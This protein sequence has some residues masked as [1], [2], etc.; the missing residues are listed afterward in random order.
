MMY[1]YTHIL[2]TC[3]MFYDLLEMGHVPLF[4]VIILLNSLLQ[5]SFSSCWKDHEDILLRTLCMAWEDFC[6]QS[7][8]IKFVSYCPINSINGVAG[9][10][11]RENITKTVH[12]SRYQQVTKILKFFT[13]NSTIFKN[14]KMLSCTLDI[15]QWVI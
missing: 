11:M 14:S 4:C 9:F 10:L 13:N 12:L 1:V 7:K 3:V 15:T 2:Y 6:L 8:S 5:N